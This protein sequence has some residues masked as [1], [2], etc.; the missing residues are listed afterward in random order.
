[1]AWFVYVE[2]NGKIQAQRFDHWPTVDGTPLEVKQSHEI[3]KLEMRARISWLM[4]K[5][6]YKPIKDLT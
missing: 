6:P 3:N 4:D 5:Y 2:R 1:M